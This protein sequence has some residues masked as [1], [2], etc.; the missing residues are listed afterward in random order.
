MLSGHMEMEIWRSRERSDINTH[1]SHKVIKTF[2]LDD[3][4][5]RENI[6][7]EEDIQGSQY[8]EVFKE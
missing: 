5:S 7:L 2:E 8:I 4:T 3:I 6:S 1:I